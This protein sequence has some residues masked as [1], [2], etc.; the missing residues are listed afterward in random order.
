MDVKHQPKQTNYLHNSRADKGRY[1]HDCRAYKRCYPQDRRADSLNPVGQLIERELHVHMYQVGEPH[2]RTDFL[3][4]DK[5][6]VEGQIQLSVKRQIYITFLIK[7]IGFISIVNKT[8]NY[9]SH[10]KYLDRFWN[11]FEKVPSLFIGA[12]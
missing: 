8:A 5:I 7:F 11:T 12:L 9:R 1:Q 10:C 2:E 6:S 4:K 3:S